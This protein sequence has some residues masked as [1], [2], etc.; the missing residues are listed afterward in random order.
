M[1]KKYPRHPY[2]DPALK[3]T[4]NGT[5]FFGAAP[6][7]AP[8]FEAPISRRE[9]FLRAARH[10]NPMWVPISYSD[11]QYR[12]PNELADERGDKQLGPRFHAP[13]PVDYTFLDSFGNS[14]TWCADAHGAMLTPGTKVVEDICDWEKLIKFPNF[15]DWN[16]REK[17]AQFMKNEYDPEKAMHVNI[18]QG[19][20]EMLVAFLGGYGEGMMA[21]AEEPEACRDFFWRF[22]QYM[23]DYFDLLNELYPVDYVTYHDDWGTERDTFFSEKMMEELVYEPTKK[24]VDHIKGAGKVFELHSCGKIERFFPYISALDIDLVWMQPRANDMQMLKAKYGDKIGFVTPMD[25]LEIGKTYT[26][27]EL[28]KIVRNNVEKYAPGGGY[29]PFLRNVDPKE[30][31]TVANELYAYSREFYE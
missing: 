8:V 11:L 19:L 6:A 18:Y 21:L 7:T 12:L 5:G 10:E 16:F 2:Q 9:N 14:W 23:T 15:D 26:D 29:V 27:D 13:S 28:V 22:A 17:A 4:T 24:I 30:T 20:T 31:W 1:M 3:T 25:G